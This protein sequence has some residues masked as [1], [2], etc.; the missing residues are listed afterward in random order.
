M[1]QPTICPLCNRDGRPWRV[2]PNGTSLICG[3]CNAQF[4]PEKGRGSYSTSTRA[5]SDRQEGHNAR[6]VGGRV[7]ANSGAGHDKGDVKVPGLLR[8]EDKTTEKASY[9][10]KLADLRK[11]AA[12]ARGD[13][14]PIMRIA[15]ED[16]LRQQY[17]VLPSDWFQQLLTAYREN[18]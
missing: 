15:F 12:A 4:R 18:R 17:V 10:L 2:A 14:I 13:E 11:V 3:L 7:T 16:D 9:V 1:P 8:E 6:R 5:R